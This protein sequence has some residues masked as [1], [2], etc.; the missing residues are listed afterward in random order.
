MKECRVFRSL[1][2]MKGVSQLKTG[3]LCGYS[4]ASIGHIEKWKDRA[5]AIVNNRGTPFVGYR[6]CLFITFLKTRKTYS[7]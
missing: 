1:R 7:F 2:R 3:E 5:L 6:Q 4:R